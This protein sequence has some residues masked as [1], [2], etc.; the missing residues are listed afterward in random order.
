VENNASRG[1]WQRGGGERQKMKIAKQKQ[2]WK[3]KKKYSL[4]RP[5]SE[6]LTYSFGFAANSLA[7]WD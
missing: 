7:A 2:F 1:T 3:R 4:S 5:L 6:R